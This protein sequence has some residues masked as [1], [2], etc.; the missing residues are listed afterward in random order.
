MRKIIY[1]SLIIPLFL[2]NAC[3]HDEKEVFDEPASIRMQKALSEYG[4]LLASSETG[5]FADYYPEDDYGIGGYAMFFKFNSN[6]TVDVSCEIETNAPAMEV[7]TSQWEMTP[8]QGPVIS[9]STY[10]PVMHYF[11]EPYSWD[12]DGRRGDYE[13]IVMKA[14]KDTI[15]MKGKK[16]GNLFVLRRNTGNLDSKTYFQE[17]AQLEDKLSEFGT[18]G[19]MLKGTRIGMVAVVDRTLSLGY[20]DENNEDQIV[21]VSY[22]FTPSGIRLSEPYTF[23]DATMQNFTWNAQEE[24]YVCTDPNIDAF[25]DVYFPEDYELR[26]SEVLGKWNIRYHGASTTT[27]VDEVVEITQKKKNATYTL[28]SPKLFS[29]PGI[30]L[31]FDSQKGILSIL[32]QNAAVQEETGYSIR[33][34]AYDRSAGYLNTAATGPVGIIGI[35]NKDQGGTRSVTFVDNGKWVTY[36]PNGFLLRLYDGST[37]MGNFTANVADY[38]FND[39]TITQIDE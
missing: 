1:L 23:Q 18:F 36:K 3:L 15:E 16:H 9:F 33:V 8:D 35:W 12:A 11:S 26:Y 21:K 4:Q 38:R 37:N 7:K 31:T 6:G 34:C 14:G 10:N 22:T 28:H 5:W 29:F 19:F 24:K 17:I 2:M 30:E 39:I 25:L 20:K 27:W 32:N 13:F